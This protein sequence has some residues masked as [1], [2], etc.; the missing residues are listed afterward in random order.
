MLW[1]PNASAVLGFLHEW[2]HAELRVQAKLKRSYTRP[3]TPVE[4]DQLLRE[5]TS[6]FEALGV[7]KALQQFTESASAKASASRS[8]STTALL[9]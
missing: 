9:F 6:V 7:L 4:S 8:S 2:S 1:E 3:P 5:S